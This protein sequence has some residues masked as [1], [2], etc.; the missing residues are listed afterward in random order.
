MAE[1]NSEAITASEN[2]PK[3]VDE[4]RTHE[5]DGMIYEDL[6]SLPDLTDNE[7]DWVYFGVGGPA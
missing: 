7:I 1:F 6:F 4:V 2:E 3:K 5:K